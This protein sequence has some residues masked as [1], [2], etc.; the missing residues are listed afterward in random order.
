VASSGAP[1]EPDARFGDPG[2]IALGTDFDVRFG[3]VAHSG[4]FEVPWTYLSLTPSADVFVARNIS[5]GGALFFR[6]DASQTV[7]LGPAY[8]RAQYV[9][10]KTTSYGAAVRV[11]VNLPLGDWISLW[12]R[13][14][15]GIWTFKVDAPTL[16]A[17]LDPNAPA[18]R[19]GY[20]QTALWLGLFAPVL[21]HPARHIFLGLGPDV[22]VDLSRKVDEATQ[23]KRTGWGV[24]SV[25]GA[26]F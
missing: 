20:T 16:N 13:A 9:D 2:R 23:K 18:L 21:V 15:V 6:Y 19:A 17:S 7:A 11:G 12:P 3:H 26:W 4:R 8:Q 10:V 5:V 25:V 24:S 1:P 14:A 22:F